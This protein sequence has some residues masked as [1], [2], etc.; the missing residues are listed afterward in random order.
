VGALRGTADMLKEAARMHR[1]KGDI[2]HARTC[3]THEKNA[4]A[5]LTAATN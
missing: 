1:L 3:E 2:G 5:A 4:R